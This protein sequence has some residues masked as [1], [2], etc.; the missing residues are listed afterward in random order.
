M[1]FVRHAK[2]IERFPEYLNTYVLGTKDHWD[3]LEKV[4]GLRRLNDLKAD[5]ILGY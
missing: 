2:R 4:G 3:Y 5:P 1:G